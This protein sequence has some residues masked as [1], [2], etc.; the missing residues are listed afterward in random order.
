MGGLGRQLGA[1][2]EDEPV[3]TCPGGLGTIGR[4]GPCRLAV[5]TAKTDGGWKVMRPHRLPTLAGQ[6]AV[7]SLA[8]ISLSGA[9]QAAASTVSLV[10]LAIVAPHSP[11]DSAPDP[12]CTTPAPAATFGEFH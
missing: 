6:L 7:T 3:L 9:P 1:P 12:A 5:F 2:V 4:V 10:P 11:K 8:L